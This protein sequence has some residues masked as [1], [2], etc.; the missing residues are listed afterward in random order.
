M[1]DDFYSHRVV[2]AVVTREPARRRARREAHTPSRA[3]LSVV[4]T[5]CFFVSTLPAHVPTAHTEPMVSAHVDH[6]SSPVGHAPLHRGDASSPPEFARSTTLSEV[7]HAGRRWRL[8]PPVVL[9]FEQD[10]DGVFCDLE[11]GGTI[12]APNVASLR[13]AINEEF[14]FLWEEYGDAD[15]HT[16]APDAIRMRDRVRRM[17]HVAT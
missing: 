14:A 10:D 12:F 7:V 2:D 5:V 4:A 8:A 17:M 16:L 9:T 3:V 11:F 6:E 15:P 13:E 1:V